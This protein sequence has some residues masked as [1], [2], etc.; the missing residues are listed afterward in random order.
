[1]RT[2]F[3]LYPFRNW[4]DLDARAEMAK[5]TNEVVGEAAIEAYD[6]G[7]ALLMPPHGSQI[8]R[9]QDSA[10]VAWSGTAA[11]TELSASV[12]R[13]ERREVDWIHWDDFEAAWTAVQ[14]ALVAQQYPL[15]CR[16][17]ANSY[18]GAQGD[19]VLLWLAPDEAAYRAAPDLTD[20]LVKQLGAEKGAQLAANLA[21]LFPVKASYDVERRLDLSNLGE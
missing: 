13:L 10:D 9:R 15:A 16:I 8:W 20:A 6:A 12:G 5:H 21:R 14:A 3:T 2:Y 18:G 19:W 17:Y 1:M 4:S 7:D 11:L